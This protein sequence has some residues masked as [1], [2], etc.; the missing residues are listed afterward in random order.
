MSCKH[1]TMTERDCSETAKIFDRARS[2]IYRELKRLGECPYAPERAHDDYLC[3]RMR[4]RAVR[5]LTSG[6]MQKY[7]LK[8]TQASQ[9]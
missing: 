1:L 7:V 2:T 6:D 3:K 8:R 4:C 9:P 5:K